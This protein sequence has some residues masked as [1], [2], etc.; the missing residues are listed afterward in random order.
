MIEYLSEISFW[1]WMILAVG[2]VIV[3]ALLPG[4][5]FMWMGIAAAVTGFILLAFPDLGWEIQLQIFAGLSVAS[6]VAGR[7]WLSRRPTKTADPTLNRRGQQYVG[8]VFTLAEPIVDGFGKVKVDDTFWK[9]QGDD[10]AIGTRV[11]VT[12]LDNGLFQVVE[13]PATGEAEKTEG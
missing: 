1:H 9:I 5:I 11:K 7:M 6:V 2:L 13:A 4:V 12:G 8:R 3:E 10:C